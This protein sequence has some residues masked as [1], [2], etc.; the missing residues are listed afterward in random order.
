MLPRRFR[1]VIIDAAEGEND[2]LQRA[3]S[4]AARSIAQERT[5][6]ARSITAAS[7]SRVI[8]S[9]DDILMEQH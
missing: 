3:G 1:N 5:T 2:E 9:V 4:I 7:F 8:T 6:L